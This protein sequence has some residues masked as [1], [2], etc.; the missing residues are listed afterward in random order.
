MPDLL[1]RLKVQSKT[2]AG[3]FG[4]ALAALLVQG[5]HL[6]VDDAEIYLP[7]VK[8]AANPALFPFASEFF[9]SHAHLSFFPNL[10][11][12]FAH[13]SHLPVDAAILFCHGLG[14]LLLLVAAWRLAGACFETAAARWGAVVLLAGALSTPVAGTALVIF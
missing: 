13:L 6:G 7:A 2:L 9:M 11:G 10:V 5:Y 14:I 4:L 3:I 1:A 8:R 12:G